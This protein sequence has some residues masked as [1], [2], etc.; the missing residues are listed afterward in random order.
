MGCVIGGMDEG[1]RA[2]DRDREQVVATLREQ[3]AQGRLTMEELEER[4]SAAYTAKTLG[5]LRALTADLPAEPPVEATRAWSPARVGWIAAAGALLAVAFIVAVAAL[6]HA[7]F[8]WPP[9]LVALVV[10]K[11]VRGRSAGARRSAR[12]S[13]AP[14]SART[15]NQP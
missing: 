15:W 11:V 8:A 9:W 2:G 5:E 10:M 3:Y 6:G 12:R 1:L 4:S 7:A 13:R 14:G